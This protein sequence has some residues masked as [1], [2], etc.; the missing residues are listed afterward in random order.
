MLIAILKAA[1]VAW[2]IGWPIPWLACRLLEGV[3]DE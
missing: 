2:L 1:V 3:N